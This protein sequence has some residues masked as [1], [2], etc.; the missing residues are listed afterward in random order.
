MIR[1]VTK[2][3]RLY[4]NLSFIPVIAISSIVRTVPYR[5]RGVL[6]VIVSIETILLNR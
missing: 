3:N 4:S 6:F 2:K 1:T 5:I